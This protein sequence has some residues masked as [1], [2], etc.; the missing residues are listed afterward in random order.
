MYY[1]QVTLF[2]LY[3]LRKP[4]SIFYFPEFAFYFIIS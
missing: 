1:V 3:I 2:L 4:I